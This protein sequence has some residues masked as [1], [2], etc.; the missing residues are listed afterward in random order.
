MT[1]SEFVL[2]RADIREVHD[3]L[4]QVRAEVATMKTSLAVCQSRCHVTTERRS[5][6]VRWTVAALTS[7][8][9]AVASAA[10]TTL[11]R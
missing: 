3:N 8:L 9:A 5:R 11:L 1:S 6:Y 10:L 7:V 2:L 4:E